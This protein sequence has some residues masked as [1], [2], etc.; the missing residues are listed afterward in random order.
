MSGNVNIII[1]RIT[2]I[3]KIENQVAFP[4]I[5]ITIIQKIFIFLSLLHE[6][7]IILTIYIITFENIT[8]EYIEVSPPLTKSAI[9]CNDM[10]I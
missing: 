9:E 6:T 2:D 3:I 1:K 7:V 5:P 8:N 4:N 10:Y